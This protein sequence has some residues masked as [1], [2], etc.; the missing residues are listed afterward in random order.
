MSIFGLY[1]GNDG[2]SHLVELQIVGSGPPLKEPLPCQGWRPFQCD[3][4]VTQAS[5]PTPV[6]GMTVMLSGCMEISVGGGALRHVALR[7]GDMLMVLDT[8]GAGH[9]TAITG[10]DKLR[11]AGVTF[12]PADWPVIRAH[13]SG[14]PDNL[15]DP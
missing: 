15:L 1:S 9:A 4:G 12:A 11:V 10:P 13:F 6:A 8:R 3:P 2:Q 7:P 5:H 14:W